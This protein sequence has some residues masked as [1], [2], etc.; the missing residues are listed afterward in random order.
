MELFNLEEEKFLDVLL[1]LC[2]INTDPQRK[3]TSARDG[4]QQAVGKAAEMQER[5]QIFTSSHKR[6]MYYAMNE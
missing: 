6:T 1:A 5:G 2:S 4:G 3:W